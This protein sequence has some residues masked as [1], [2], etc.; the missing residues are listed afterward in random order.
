MT[1]EQQQS[2]VK[3]LQAALTTVEEKWNDKT[4]SQA[5]M[6]FGFDF[7]DDINE[8]EAEYNSAA[9]EQAEQESYIQPY[10][11]NGVEDLKAAEEDIMKRREE[12]LKIGDLVAY[13]RFVQNNPLTEQEI[14]RKTAVN[15]FDTALLNI[16]RDSI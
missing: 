6:V 16:Q 5:W 1:P 14:F 11:L 8:I 9:R 10:H 13:N 2:I 7:E 12:Y 3:T 15:N 4:E